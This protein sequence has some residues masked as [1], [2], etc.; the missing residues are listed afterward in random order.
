MPDP[1][2]QP[3]PPTITQGDSPEQIAAATKNV[4]DIFDRVAPKIGGKETEKAPVTPPARQETPPVEPPLD[5][6]P[7]PETPD[8]TKPPPAAKPPETPAPSDP[9]TPSFIDK[10]LRGEPETPPAAAPVDEE[11]PEELP[12]FKTSDDA[13]ARYKNWREAH[14][15]LREENR[16][17]REKPILDDATASR[18]KFLEG[19][20]VEQDKQLSAMS[21]NMHPDFQR[22]IIQPLYQV[23]NHAAKVVQESGGNAENLAKAL[24]LNGRA[25]YEA[26]DE[27]LSD[28]PESARVEVNGAI[29]QYRRLDEAR[30]AALADA[31]RTVETLKK[32]DL[33]RQMAYYDTQKKQMAVMFDEA[34]KELREKAKIEVLQKSDDPDAKQWNERADAIVE[35]AKNLFLENKD[36]KRMAFAVAM[37]PMAD[38]YR[39]LWLKERAARAKGDKL[40]S[41]RLGAEPNLSE[42]GGNVPG[43]TPTIEE[44]LKTPFPQ[45]F[46]REFHRQ[47]EKGVR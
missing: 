12:T 46:L 3:P 14:K 1:V 33:E 40:I 34:I 41:D 37:A 22:N 31:P 44:D 24:A 26:I 11:W 42:S 25:Q 18:L 16:E 19:K 7:P 29:A 20:T 38:V 39:D 5:T 6:K 9:S 36:L 35:V 4:Q 45:V 30:R 8:S 2:I 47:R 10:I 15:K 27:V 32:N 21:V 17:L 23:W 13:K 43:S 28:I